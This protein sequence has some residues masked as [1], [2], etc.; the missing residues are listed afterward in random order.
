MVHNID[1]NK[2][3]LT[4]LNSLT[5][6]FQYYFILGTMG[7]LVAYFTNI[8]WNEDITTLKTEGERRIKLKKIFFK[9]VISAVHITF[10][11]QY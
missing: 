9:K 8:E 6:S 5:C 3:A 11:V 4:Y 10:D 2:T 1:T 7:T